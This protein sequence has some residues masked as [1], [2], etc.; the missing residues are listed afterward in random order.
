MRALLLL[1]ALA[2]PAAVWAIH[3][4]T[5]DARAP[6]PDQLGARGA[7]W[8]D[9]G[10]RATVDEVA[11][12]A[13]TAW[14]PAG[15]DQVYPLGNGQTLWLRFVLAPQPGHAHWYAEIP[16]ANLDHAT[17]YARG[18]DGRWRSHSAGDHLPVSDWAVPGRQPVLPLTTSDT[19][20]VEHLLRI[21]HA[22]P[23]SVPLLLTEEHQLLMRE[24]G[25]AMGLGV[26]FGITLL[27]CV[28]A[29]AA[30]VWM[31]DVAAALFVPPTVLLGLSAASFAG[32]S[33]W[34]LWPRHAIWNDLS[35]FAIPT[36]ALVTMLI[37]VYVATAFGTR[38]PRARLWP[39]ALAAVGVTVIVAMPFAPDAVSARAMALIC[40]LLLLTC[41]ALPAWTWWRGG[42]RHALGLLV[43]MVCLA[44]PASTH[45][46]RLLAIM[47][48]GLISRFVLLSGAALQLSVV[49]VTLMWRGRD[50]GLTRQRMRGLGRADPATGL[51]TQAAVR[52]QLRRMTA[53][54]QRQ[55]HAYAVLLIDLVNLAQVRQKFG[56]RA[57][58][59]LPLHLA[60]RLLD[61]RREVDTIGR[62]GDTRFVMLIDGPI[63]ADAASRLAQQV[64]A[65]CRRPIGGRPEGW[66]PRLRMALAVLP[67]DGQNPEV[68]LDE[69]AVMLNT[70]APGDT[71]ALF[72]RT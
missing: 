60:D 47:P 44:A 30:A 29:L 37:F 28:I 67:R 38:A 26:Y 66:T 64:L 34:L 11:A 21:E 14:R 5:L 2:V 48:T 12:Q 57:W 23:T 53:R 54:A 39:L 52:E 40:S 32:V 43:G 6:L 69:L 49:L 58:Q 68:V 63:S 8:L 42:D 20:P 31:R 62:L 25:V 24:R 19:A 17:L 27:G 41:I 16:L 61:S 9:P 51:A 65:H 50:R 7:Y 35:A 36:L 10:G 33:G 59:E 55:Q 71:R 18:A 1:L 46:L 72:Q 45:I 15:Q 13:A 22:F 56:R 4:L 70:V 3:P